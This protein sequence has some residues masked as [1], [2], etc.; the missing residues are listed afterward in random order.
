MVSSS[1]PTRISAF[2]VL[3]NAAVSSIPSCFTVLK[4]V[5][6]NVTVYVPGTRLMILY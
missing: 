2:V 5:S 4:P 3:V 6:A 1:D